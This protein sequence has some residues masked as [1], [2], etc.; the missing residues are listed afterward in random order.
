MSVETFLT[1]TGGPLSS[2]G[3]RSGVLAALIAQALGAS[4]AANLVIGVVAALAAAVG[5]GTLVFRQMTRAWRAL[6][7]RFP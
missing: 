1:L 4:E 2:G 3:A 7:P 5:Y 6:S